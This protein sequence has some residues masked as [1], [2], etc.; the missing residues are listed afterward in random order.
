MSTMKKRAPKKGQLVKHRENTS[1]IVLYPYEVARELLISEA[2]AYKLMALG[3]SHEG[4]R[5]M[6][7]G[8]PA[9]K[10]PRKIV[11][12]EDLA[13]FV[14]FKRGLLTREAY[15]KELAEAGRA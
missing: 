11:H 15:L 10:R 2:E 3:P 9:G 12:R 8:D 1:T 7:L 4:I 6:C 13:S 14:R 5:A